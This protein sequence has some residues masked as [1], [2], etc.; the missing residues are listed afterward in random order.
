MLNAKLI[1]IINGTTFAYGFDKKEVTLKEVVL[2]SVVE[3]LRDHRV[4]TN[5][6]VLAKKLG[7]YLLTPVDLVDMDYILSRNI[8]GFIIAPT[9]QG[10]EYKWTKVTPLSVA[11]HASA[12]YKMYVEQRGLVTA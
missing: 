12:I 5:D 7:K 1:Y 11:Q 2:E 4:V 10:H 9:M 8:T 6:P 3:K